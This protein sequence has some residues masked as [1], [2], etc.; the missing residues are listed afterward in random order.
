MTDDFTVFLRKRST[1]LS[2]FNRGVRF[3]SV[4]PASGAE[5]RDVKAAFRV[6][7]LHLTG[8]DPGV[9]RRERHGQRQTP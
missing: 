8:R 4:E 6:R 3:A 9:E 7:A 1:N 2:D 5:L